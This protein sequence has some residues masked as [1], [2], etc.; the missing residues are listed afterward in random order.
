ML[1]NMPD[2]EERAEEKDPPAYELPKTDPEFGDAE[3]DDHD[4]PK[5]QEEEPQQAQS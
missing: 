5:D 3:V 4:L 2:V 1:E